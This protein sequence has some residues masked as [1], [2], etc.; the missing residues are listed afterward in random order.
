MRLDPP[1]IVQAAVDPAVAEIRDLAR[2]VTQ[3][4]QVAEKLPAWRLELGRRLVARRKLYPVSGPRAGGWAKELEQIGITSQR[5][6]EY[7]RLAGVV[8]D[9]PAGGEIPSLRAAGI[10]SSGGGIPAVAGSSPAGLSREGWPVAQLEVAPALPPP[11][12]SPTTA[13]LA[14]DGLPVFPE[15]ERAKIREQEDVERIDRH[16]A[17][18]G[19]HMEDREAKVRELRSTYAE[20]QSLI[21]RCHQRRGIHL[22]DATTCPADFDAIKHLA[23]DIIDV[24]LSELEGAGSDGKTRR[25]QLLLLQGGSQ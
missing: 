25:T 21:V 1:A 8:E 11:I 16:V 10:K 9:L 13:P 23:A 14:D 5:A 3:G 24:L 20:A 2:K 22:S 18:M 19:G 6:S 4:E 15:A 7:M 12:S 17:A